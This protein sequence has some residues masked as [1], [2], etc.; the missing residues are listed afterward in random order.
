MNACGLHI[1]KKNV[2]THFIDKDGNEYPMKEYI[3]HGWGG[4]KNGLKDLPKEGYPYT[5]KYM[6]EYK[7]KCC[8]MCSCIGKE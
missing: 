8:Q 3:N 2:T 6:I 7:W 5:V 4:I 1:F